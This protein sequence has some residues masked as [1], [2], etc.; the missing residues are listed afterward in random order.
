M[1]PERRPEVE[2]WIRGEVDLLAEYEKALA[3]LDLRTRQRDRLLERVVG[4]YQQC[5]HG[6][7][8]PP[9]PQHSC[10]GC[11]GCEVPPE[12]QRKHPASMHEVTVLD[13]TEEP[14]LTPS[15]PVAQRRIEQL[16][17][18]RDELRAKVSRVE[19]F[20]VNARSD[21]DDPMPWRFVRDLDA[22]LD[23]PLTPLEPSLLPEGPG[24]AHEST[25]GADGHEHDWVSITAVADP[26]EVQVCQCGKTRTIRDDLEETA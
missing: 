26:V 9:W 10:D 14:E 18:E 25:G 23:A 24:T 8:H 16:E 22:A 2:A 15:D 12:Y 1:T 13:M 20:L 6:Y 21:E 19:A 11:F 4:T 5:E 7:H 3:E 17:A